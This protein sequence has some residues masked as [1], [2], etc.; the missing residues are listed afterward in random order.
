MNNAEIGVIEAHIGGIYDG[1][2]YLSPILNVVTNHFLEHIDELGGTIK[3]IGMHKCGIIKHKL[4]IILG[5]AINSQTLDIYSRNS[6][7]PITI[8]YPTNQNYTFDE[9]NSKTAA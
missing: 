7:A 6:L 3:K 2:N 1:T 8:I 5:H 9:L 4:P